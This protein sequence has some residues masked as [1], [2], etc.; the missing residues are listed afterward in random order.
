MLFIYFSPC[1]LFKSLMSFLKAQVSF[2][3]KSSVPNITPLYF[4]SSKYIIYFGQTSQLKSKFFRFSSARVKIRQTPHVSFEMKS[5]FLSKFCIILHCHDITP[6]QIL[7][8]YIF[9]FGQKN[10]IKVPILTLSSALVKI[11]QIPHV[12]FQTTISS[13]FASLYSATED[14]SSVLF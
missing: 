11:C 9:Y 10:P 8:S 5:Q 7:S 6:L 13:N 12:I 3:S 14:N 1:K 2:P 4:F